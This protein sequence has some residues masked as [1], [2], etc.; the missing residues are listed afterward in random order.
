[1][2]PRTVAIVQARMGS[3]RLPGKVLL[4]QDG[5]SILTYIV[6]RLR[7]TECLDQIVVATTV[8]PRDDILVEEC[9]RHEIDCFRGSEHDV[10]ARYLGAAIMTAA[11]IIV[12]VTGDNPFTDPGSIDRVVN[13]I[14]E[15][16]AEYVL[17]NGL[18]VGT[19]GEALTRRLLARMAETAY[20]QRWREH[21]TLYAKEN[22]AATGGVFLE[23]RPSCACPE[24]SLTVDELPDYLRAHEVANNMEGTDFDLPALIRQAQATNYAN[25]SFERR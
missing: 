12:R 19:A 20:E 8:H 11:E 3:S 10:L 14:L 5:R 24:L 25:S 23:A 7:H 17:E 15:T 22:L 18:P 4:T 9:R 2:R 1:M 13:H 21:V 16:G 6:E